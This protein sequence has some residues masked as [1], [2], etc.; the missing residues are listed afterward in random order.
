MCSALSRPE[1]SG[2]GSIETERLRL[3]PQAPADVPA[4][5]ALI[6]DYDVA[7]MTTRI[8][9]PYRQEDVAA[10][11]A[12]L[13]A[14]D[15]ARDLTLRIETRAGELVGGAGAHRGEA[16]L[17]EIG[18]WIGRAFWGRG[19]ATEATR[20]LCA[21]LAGAW[22]ARGLQAGH[23]ADNPASARVLEKAGFLYTGVR[24]PRL[25]LARGEPAET[26]LMVWLA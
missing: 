25:S 12:L 8:P 5:A 10:F 6:D 22:S 2:L 11:A 7:R 15:P 21:H 18:Y 23:F 1:I 3:R 4:I 13:A 20:G 24:E 16:L 14:R 9:H 17:P 19:Y 26:R